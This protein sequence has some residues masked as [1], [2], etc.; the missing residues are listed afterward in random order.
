MAKDNIIVGLDIGSASIRTVIAQ[1][2]SVEEIPRVIGVGSAPSA[3]IRRG[4]VVDADET[5]QSIRQSIEAAERMANVQVREAIVSIGG[6]GVISQYS[7]GVVAV[8]RA[9]GEVTED[10]VNRVI[11]AAQTISIP[12]N[13]EIIHILP[14]S[15]RLDDQENIKDPLGMSGVRLEVD[16]LIIEGPAPN[17]KNLTKV[18]EQAGVEVEG[19]VLGALAAAKAVLNKKQKELGVVLVDMGEG[20]TSL[21][22]F[23]EGDLL[24][25]AT[26]PIGAGHIT[27]DVAIGLRTSIPVAEKVKLE[28]GSALSR[29][30]GKKDD[31][32]LSVIDSQ[33]EGL[34]SRYHVAE[35]IE[36]RLE[37]IFSL[38]NKELK[39]IGKAGLLP[40]GAVLTGGG[41]KLPQIVELA[42]VTLGLP[43]Q[44][45]FPAKLG[46]IL[47]KVDDPS[48]ATAVGL[49]LWTKEQELVTR[50]KIPGAKMLSGIS[51]SA[52]SALDKMRRWLGKFLP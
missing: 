28:Y 20:T 23:E 12:L 34:V 15:Y 40:A 18:L 27:N 33:E 31:I 7:K 11:S 24:H 48:F 5:A 14:R 4:S 8:G 46:G 30:I 1:D 38:I 45:G 37:E 29:D 41:A 26:L 25:T 3:G 10:D 51:S 35:I 39:S 6:V 17:V 47:D 43:A 50:R 22:V 9:D 32:D 42:K 52:G 16:A 36:A 19:M 49:I 44:V 21:A 2:S 13:R